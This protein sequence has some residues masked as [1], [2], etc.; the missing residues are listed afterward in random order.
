MPGS[1]LRERAANRQKAIQWERSDE[2]QARLTLMEVR[3]QLGLETHGTNHTTHLP[4]SSRT[5]RERRETVMRQRRAVAAIDALG[6][7]QTRRDAIRE[8]AVGAVVADS[9][10]EVAVYS[11]E[12]EGDV[13]MTE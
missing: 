6:L 8:A 2:N 10:R 7:G 12:D 1:T 13:M 9:N 3:R 5:G 4:R 11:D